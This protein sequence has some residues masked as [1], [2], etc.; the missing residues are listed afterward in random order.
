MPLKAVRTMLSEL[1]KI[2]GDSLLEQM[3]VLPA[4]SPCVAYLNRF[5]TEYRLNPPRDL[6]VN[7]LTASLPSHQ[8]NNG[9]VGGQQAGA[10]IRQLLEKEKQ[11][12]AKA[13]AAAAASGA[14][15][16]NAPTTTN[17]ITGRAEVTSLRQVMNAITAP[18]N[19]PAKLP[20]RV[21][22]HFVL[23]HQN[24]RLTQLID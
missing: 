4:E 23:I 9:G 20:F 19:V 14:S 7:A 10:A 21:C 13:A 6:H 24:I 8:D 5:L 12:A 17:A 18:P 16:S 15:S 11:N 3:R 2:K 22:H 1:A